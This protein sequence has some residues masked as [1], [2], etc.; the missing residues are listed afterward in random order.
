MQMM[1]RRFPKPTLIGSSV[2]K[3]AIAFIK[4]DNLSTAKTQG[5]S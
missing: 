4:K 3:G 5:S 2:G 1:N